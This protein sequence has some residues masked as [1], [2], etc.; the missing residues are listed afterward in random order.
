MRC[1][2]CYEIA[3]NQ[4]YGQATDPEIVCPS[5]K[6]KSLP[7][8]WLTHDFKPLGD[9]PLDI[10]RAEARESQPSQN[11][12]YWE[13]Q[14]VAEKYDWPAPIMAEIW[15]LDG[16]AFEVPI[17]A[18]GKRSG[19]QYWAHLYE[20]AIQPRLDDHGKSADRG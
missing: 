3:D 5:C 2:E 7:R 20:K 8:A 15:K 18:K 12:R 13:L 10:D 4:S 16:E 6:I 14:Q 11:P 9:P 1:P 19:E 17:A